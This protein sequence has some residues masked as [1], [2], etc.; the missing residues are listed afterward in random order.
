MQ[1]EK[2]DLDVRGSSESRG[3]MSGE[4]RREAILDVATEIFLSEGYASA[5]MSTIA[6]KLGGSKGTLYNYFKSK[7]EL[8]EAYVRRHCVM[9]KSEIVAILSEE[10][11]ARERLTAWARHYLKVVTG[12]RSLSNWRVVAAES[13]KAPDFGRIFYESGPLLGANLLADYLRKEGDTFVIDDYLMAAH[14]F[15]SL[16]NGR[17]SKALQLNYMPSPTEAEINE[18]VDAA[19]KVFFAAYGA[20]GA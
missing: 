4:D 14:Q 1:Y 8:F 17:L 10:G 9:Q 20:Q 19:I 16:C 18:E 15:L 7:E 13:Q 2:V 12:E 6:A 3:R 11:T 5:S